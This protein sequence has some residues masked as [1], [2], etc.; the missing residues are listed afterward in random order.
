MSF[1][2]NPDQRFPFL[3]VHIT[4]QS[5]RRS[6][7]KNLGKGFFEDIFPY[8]AEAT[9][10]RMGIDK[11]ICRM[12]SL[13]VEANIRKLRRLEL[14]YTCI[15]KQS[16]SFTQDGEPYTYTGKNEYRTILAPCQDQ[17]WQR[18]D[19]FSTKEYIHC[20]HMP[21]LGRIPFRH[22]YGSKI[23]ILNFRK[24]LQ[25]RKGRGYYSQNPLRT[26]E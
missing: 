17:E 20:Y 2:M 5:V 16:Y 6:T 25:F 9:V 14:I 13:M 8:I 12:D 11:R 4:T 1:R 24:L 7:R 10:R 19:P 15:S 21:V 3:I 22:F 18:N 26:I 23:A